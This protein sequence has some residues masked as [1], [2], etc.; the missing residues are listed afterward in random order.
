MNQSIAR[1]RWLERKDSIQTVGT[2]GTVLSGADS[3]SMLQLVA[4]PMEGNYS[5][6]FSYADHESMYDN[7][8]QMSGD[9]FYDGIITEHFPEGYCCPADISIGDESFLTLDSLRITRL[10]IHNVLDQACDVSF[11]P[12]QNSFSTLGEDHDAAAGNDEDDS[13]TL[14]YDDFHD[15]PEG[16]KSGGVDK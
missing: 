3:V 14:E 15:L 7:F 2:D 13:E 4:D 6:S 11:L 8:S 16:S 5:E 12:R 10:Q 1:D 9:D